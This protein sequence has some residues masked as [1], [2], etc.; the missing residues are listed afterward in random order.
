MRLAV[1]DMDGV[2]VDHLSSWAVVHDALGTDNT[3]ALVAFMEGRID[4]R[5]FIRRDVALWRSR[6]PDLSEAELLAILAPTPRMP[7]MREAIRSLR[8]QGT[9]CAIVSGGLRPLAELVA[10]EGGFDTVR[11]NGVCFGPDGRLADDA[12]IEVPLRA[13]GEVVRAIQE[14]LGV[15]PA[16]T[17]AVGDSAFDRGLFE[18]SRVSVAFNPVDD[19]VARAATHAVW[20]KDLRAAVAPLIDGARVLR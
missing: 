17:G 5:Q 7:G 18:R 16:D 10:R 15:G 3:D 8:A 14:E 11:A 4:D 13:K 6:R 2:L 12:R 1:F 20:G 9:K 19:E